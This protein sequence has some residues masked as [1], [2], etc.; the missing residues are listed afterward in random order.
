[1]LA[2][3]SSSEELG[4]QPGPLNQG[5]SWSLGH[6]LSQGSWEEEGK[7]LWAWLQWTA[8]NSGTHLSCLHFVHLVQIFIPTFSPLP[9]EE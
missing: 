3:L 9:V 8:L 7:C 5:M 2:R 6:Q 4:A 1:M